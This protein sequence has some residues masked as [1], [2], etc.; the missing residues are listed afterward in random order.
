[1]ADLEDL[2]GDRKKLSDF[3]ARVEDLMRWIVEEG[4]RELVP[5][6]LRDPSSTAWPPV[7]LRF[8]NVRKGANFR[9]CGNSG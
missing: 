3:L 7:K 2:T 6:G 8:E 1:M 4:G 5:E 9:T